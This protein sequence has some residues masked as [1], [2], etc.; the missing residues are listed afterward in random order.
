MY[1]FFVTVHPRPP[2][3]SAG[4][5][6]EI[7]GLKVATLNIPAE[8]LHETAPWCSFET[9]ETR[10]AALPRM[11]IEP[12]GSFVWVAGEGEPGWQVDGNLY[13][14]HEQLLYVELKGAC[15]APAF[16]RLLGALEWPR[17]PLM[18]Q[19]THEALLMDEAEFRRLAEQRG[20]TAG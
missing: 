6:V 9:A 17:T 12:D 10:L 14:R 1:A 7:A 2:Q 13:D 8:V 19:W 4:E 3:A 15:P 16:D 11:F 18:F 5:S 20:E